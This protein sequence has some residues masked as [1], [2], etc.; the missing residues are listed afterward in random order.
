MLENALFFDYFFENRVSVWRSVT[1]HPTLQRLLHLCAKFHYIPSN[2]CC[3][4]EWKVWFWSPYPHYTI[5]DSNNW[6]MQG[7]QL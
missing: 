4:W 6:F 1:T 7:V 3:C 2:F 5:W